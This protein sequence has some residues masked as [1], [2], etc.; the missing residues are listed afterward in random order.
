MIPQRQDTRTN[1]N[2]SPPYRN[3]SYFY[4]HNMVTYKTR[5]P[6]PLHML[7]RI[8]VHYYTILTPILSICLFIH[9]CPPLYTISTHILCLA[10]PHILVNTSH[11]RLHTH[12]VYHAPSLRFNPMAQTTPSPNRENTWLRWCRQTIPIEPAGRLSSC[13]VYIQTN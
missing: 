11:P 12:T 8:P 13:M 10:G 6:A 1:I 9:T 4:R 7:T 3:K 2:S 5:L